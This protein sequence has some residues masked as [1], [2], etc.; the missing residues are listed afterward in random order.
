MPREAPSGF[1][2]GRF[3]MFGKK[4]RRQLT[5]CGKNAEGV[6]RIMQTLCE[7]DQTVALTD[8]EH[9]ALQIA[10]QMA[11]DVLHAINTGM[12]VRVNEDA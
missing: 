6:A 2:K 8:E 4:R 3:E 11:G 1:E 9:E 12:P 7:I 5:Y 10:V